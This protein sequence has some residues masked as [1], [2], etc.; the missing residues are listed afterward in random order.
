VSLLAVS[1]LDRLGNVAATLDCLNGSKVTDDR[2]QGNR[3]SCDFQVADPAGVFSPANAGDLLAPG[4]TSGYIIKA[5][6]W[7]NPLGTFVVQTGDVKDTGSERTVEVTGLDLSWLATNVPTP[8][9]W[10]VS[11][12]TPWSW[13]FADFLGEYLPNLDLSGFTFL[14]WPSPAI[15]VNPGSEAWTEMATKWAPAVGMELFVGP[16]DVGYL[17]PVLDPR[18]QEPSWSFL[19]GDGCGMTAVEH[20]LT[21]DSCPNVFQRDGVGP[22]N[23]IISSAAGDDNPLSS[24]YIGTYGYRLDYK[25][26]TL[27]ASQ[28]QADSAAQCQLFLGLGANEPVVLTLDPTIYQRGVPL[29]GQMAQVT[30]QKAG[31]DLAYVVMDTIEHAFFPGETTTV[32]GRRVARWS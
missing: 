24:S 10:P 2:T 19:E 5:N 22:G 3:R 12:G 32:T 29:S 30:R 23:L 20:S 14:P 7:G 4:S 13:A 9:A 11:A 26:D 18:T 25:Q 28:P 6:T 8:S 27:I 31:L 15:V 21:D 1:V 17:V 16:D